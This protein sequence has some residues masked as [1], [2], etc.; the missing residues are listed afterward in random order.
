MDRLLPA[1]GAGGEK[2]MLDHVAQRESLG[3]Q[4]LSQVAFVWARAVAIAIATA[5]ERSNI[6]PRK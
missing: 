3:P 1:T 5:N 2:T 6:I 4:Q